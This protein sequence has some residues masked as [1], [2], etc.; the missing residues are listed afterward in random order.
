MKLLVPFLSKSVFM[1]V[2]A[3][4]NYKTNKYGFTMGHA[5]IKSFSEY[6][7]IKQDTQGSDQVTIMAFERFSIFDWRF[8]PS[9]V[10]VPRENDV[11]IVEMDDGVMYCTKNFREDVIQPL[12]EIIEN[13]NKE[14]R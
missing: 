12:R 6:L 11:D 2:N 1:W 8:V 13:I 7:E 9:L 3:D 14:S 4:N 5:L 10:F